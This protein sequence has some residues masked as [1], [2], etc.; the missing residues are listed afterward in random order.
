MVNNE[1][2][3]TKKGRPRI[4]DEKPPEIKF[5]AKLSRDWVTG[6]L[7]AFLRMSVEELKEVTKDDRRDAIDWW[8][9]RIVE[10]G[11]KNGD[12]QSL[13]FMF[14]RLIGKVSD[15]EEIDTTKPIIIKTIDGKCI[16]MKLSEPQ[17]TKDEGEPKNE[18]E[19]APDST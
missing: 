12:H 8:V 1:D 10:K 9:A 19:I 4:H 13:D 3:K 11:I 16:E 5:A 7:A 18:S 6:K 17:S 2:K 14:N 15:P